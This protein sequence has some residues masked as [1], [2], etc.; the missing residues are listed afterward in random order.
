MRATGLV[1]GCALL[2][3]MASVPAGTAGTTALR[4]QSAR[5]TSARQSVQLMAHFSGG[6]AP[7]G[8]VEATQPNP[9][10]GHAV[11]DVPAPGIS[12]AVATAT[13]GG[14]RTRITMQAGRLRLT[15]ASAAHAFTYLGYRQAGPAGLALVL[16]RSAVPAAGAHPHFGPAGCLTVRAT[17]I[18]SVIRASGRESGLFEHSF[19][20]RLRSRSGA[21]VSQRTVTASGNWAV[22]LHFATQAGTVATLETYAASAK[23][24]SLACLA[25]VRVTRS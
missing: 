1:A 15:F 10:G 4:L 22:N 18:G 5:V 21:L 6:R 17:V 16:W 3:A 2:A 20:V 19:L 12:T 7:M 23:D 14:L 24:G 8:I 13:G 11:V 9:F 25:Q